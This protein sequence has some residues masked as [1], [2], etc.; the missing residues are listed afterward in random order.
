MIQ[1][2]LVLWIY[3]GLQPYHPECTPSHLNL[4]RIVKGEK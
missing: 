1:S 2:Y 4:L 3:S